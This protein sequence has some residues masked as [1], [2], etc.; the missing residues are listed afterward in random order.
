MRKHG[1]ERVIICPSIKCRRKIEE[2]ILLNNLSTTPAEQ[3]PACPYCFTKVN[4]NVK[5]A[6]LAG[7]LLTAFGSIILA[8]V[9]WLTWYDVTV[10]N[11]DLFLIFFGSRTGEAI[12]LG[13][14]MKVIYYFLIGLA[15]LV[16]GL[17]SFLRRRSK[18]VK[19]HPSTTIPEKEKGLSKCPYYFGYIKKL[20]KD[21]YTPDECLRC[22]RIRECRGL[23]E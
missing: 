6:N 8:W 3:Y 17:C 18:A 2:P 15:L 19:L 11:K 13:I 5:Q 1:G 20:D 10:W 4:T 22:S 12:S 14:G 16:P 21:L 9:G 23:I 7:S